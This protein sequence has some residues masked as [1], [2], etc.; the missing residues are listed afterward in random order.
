MTKKSSF[1]LL[2][3]AITLLSLS[4]CGGGGGGSSSQTPAA[5]AEAAASASVAAFTAY[6]QAQ[7][8]NGSEAAEPNPVT[9]ISPPVSDTTEP[10]AI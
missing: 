10:A 5:D 4:A 2:A 1:S 3:A 6:T 9:R 8:A 7:I